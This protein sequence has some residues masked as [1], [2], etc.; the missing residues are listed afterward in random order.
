MEF[1][2]EEKHTKKELVWV[3]KNKALFYLLM[4]VWFLILYLGIMLM[5]LTQNIINDRGVIILIGIIVF[6]L[7]FFGMGHILNRFWDIKI[8]MWKA[9]LKGKSINI[10]LK[11]GNQII[12][13][14][15]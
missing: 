2:V 5:I 14:A 6:I 1:F 4:M 11:D 8:A 9:K 3:L 10:E 12:K 15:K 7:G 13:I